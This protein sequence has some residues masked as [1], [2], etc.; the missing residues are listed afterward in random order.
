MDGSAKTFLCED[1]RKVLSTISMQIDKKEK[2][3]RDDRKKTF[4]YADPP[5]LSTSNN[6][7]DGF[8]E[9]DTADLFQI[10]VDSGCKF[11]LSEFKNDI[12]IEIAIS[13]NLNVIEIG[14]RHSMKKRSTEILILNYESPF[15]SNGTQNKLF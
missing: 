6:Y 8:T 1:F 12:V 7:Q 11:A 10:L 9:T 3:K 15:L 2:G 13:H 5:Y 14:E 4:I